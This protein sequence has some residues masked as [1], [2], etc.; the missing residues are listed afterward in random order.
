MNNSFGQFRSGQLSEYLFPISYT[1]EDQTGQMKI[2]SNTGIFINKAV[3]PSNPFEAIDGNGKIQSYYIKYNIYKKKNIQQIIKVYLRNTNKNFD[4]IKYLKTIV[5]PA[6]ETTDYSTFELVF[7]PN[8]SFSYNEIYFELQRSS[9]TDK[10]KINL[11]ITKLDKV[12]NV[13][14]FLEKTTENQMIIKKIKISSSPYLIFV[15][16]G[17][18][19]KIGKT[20]K[21]ETN[22][23][24]KIS[25]IGFIVLNNESFILDYQY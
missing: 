19:I 3:V 15:V 23:E 5:V 17:E 4:D 14:E 24:L 12:Y 20:G 7:S 25:S 13:I 8:D 9:L 22:D 2:S 21:Y 10:N 6:G 18:P 1:V 16:N 11:F